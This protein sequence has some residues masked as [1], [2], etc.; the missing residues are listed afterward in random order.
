MLE[1]SSI[2]QRA[3]RCSLIGV[4]VTR[5]VCAPP[6]Q[7]AH[8]GMIREIPCAIRAARAIEEAGMMSVSCSAE[9]LCTRM[10]FLTSS[11]SYM[12]VKN[13][14]TFLFRL[15]SLMSLTPVRRFKFCNGNN[16]CENVQLV[17]QAHRTAV[18]F[19]ENTVSTEN[20]ECDFVRLDGYL[21]PHNSSNST[22]RTLE[23]EL[24]A[25]IDAGT[26]S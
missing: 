20:I 24:L 26:V 18:D 17:A 5:S 11:Q 1:G 12:D 16:S 10:C 8:N 3:G 7:C 4:G 23:K 25:S 6:V 21:Y 22:F 9:M 15:V 19:I 2:L 13:L 14:K